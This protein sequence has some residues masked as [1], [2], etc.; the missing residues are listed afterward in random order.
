M[1]SH[2]SEFDFALTGD[3]A[4]VPESVSAA[5]KVKRKKTLRAMGIKPLAA[6]SSPMMTA[7]SEPKIYGTGKGRWR[8]SPR[9]I[10]RRNG[11]VRYWGRP[12]KRKCESPRYVSSGHCC[13]CHAIHAAER[14]SL[15]QS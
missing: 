12:C 13:E 7:T 11:L 14:A 5:E 1:V 3:R 8:D 4:K 6:F 10:A 2:F 9:Q 15:S